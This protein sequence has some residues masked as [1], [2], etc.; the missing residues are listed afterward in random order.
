[1][2]RRQLLRVPLGEIA[3]AGCRMFAS[4]ILN[5]TEASTG[6]VE[7]INHLCH[8]CSSVTQN[9]CFGSRTS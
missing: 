3:Q 1:M 4:K 7:D 9:K 8:N 6:R 2:Q 5:E